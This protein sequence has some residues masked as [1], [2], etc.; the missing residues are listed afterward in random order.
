MAAMK[1][2]GI[3]RVVI[4]AVIPCVCFAKSSGTIERGGLGF[5]FSDHNSF[6]NPGHFA[7]TRGFAL[8]A[9]YDTATSADGLTMGASTSMVYGSGNF[10]F[11]AFGNRSGS[12]LTTTGSFNDFAGAGLGFAAV[13]GKVLVGLGYRREVSTEQ[14]DDGRVDATMTVMSA[15]GMSIGFGATSQINAN[16]D[17]KRTATVAVGFPMSNGFSVEI[18]GTVNDLSATTNSTASLYATRSG[19]K[20]FISIGYL[21]HNSVWKH[22]AAA[23]LGFVLGKSVDISAYASHVFISGNNPAYGGSIRFAL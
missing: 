22:G 16:A 4:L 12:S 6:S 2:S 19:Q 14:S 9:G 23:R 21:W 1:I 3:A 8:D 17:E 7:A 13:K 18:D 15:K 10:G 5:L 20:A 11:G